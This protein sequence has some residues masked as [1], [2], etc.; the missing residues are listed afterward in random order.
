MELAV[1]E[2]LSCYASKAQQL[3]LAKISELALVSENF[4]LTGGTALSVFYL[5]HRVSEDID[6]F[7]THFQDLSTIDIILKRSFAD[8][9][10]VVQS[11]QA[12]YSYLIRGIKT[13]VV[14]DPLSAS[15]VRQFVK[16]AGGEKV[17]VD[18]LDNIAS[19]KLAAAAS[20]S[21]PKD[22]VDLYFISQLVW[23]GNKEESL[24]AC[25]EMAKR[26]EALLDDPA[27]AAYQI[28]MLYDRVSSQKEKILPPLKKPIDWRSF[29]ENV[30][31]VI[32][33]IYHM[34]TW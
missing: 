21:E 34:D 18:T 22:L 10:A 5:Q 15:Q 3:V 20:R 19:N 17:L 25:Y 1:K 31:S 12:F 26:K 33:T 13:D 30:R 27:T 6:L 4:F 11:S 23:S 24:L 29:Q 16:I 7:S 9:L 28:E 14:F 32:D 8:E 2:D